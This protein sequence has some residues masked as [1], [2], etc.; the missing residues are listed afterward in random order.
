MGC[1][2]EAQLAQ[3]ESETDL[4][5]QS[6]ECKKNRLNKQSWKPS[7]QRVSRGMSHYHSHE[8]YVSSTMTRKDCLIIVGLLLNLSDF[9]G[10]CQDSPGEE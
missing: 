2:Q 4:E 1:A 8:Q 7:E 9:M 3:M 10:R 5:G 6:E